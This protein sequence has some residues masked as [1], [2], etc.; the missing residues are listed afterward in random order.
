MHQS[1]MNYISLLFCSFRENRPSLR[2]VLCSLLAVFFCIFLGYAAFFGVGALP[3][4]LLQKNIVKAHDSGFFEENYPQVTVIAKPHRVDMY[5]ECFGVG[6]A[7]QPFSN[8]RDI[9]FTSSYGHCADLSRASAAQFVSVEPVAYYRYTHGYSIFVRL[10]YTYFDVQTVRTLVTAISCILLLTLTLCLKLRVSTGHALLVLGSFFLLN[11]PSMYVL[12]THAAQFWLVLIACIIVTLL[13]NPRY[14]F[15]IMA[16]VGALDG[17]V[18]F[19]SMGSL[20]LSMPL[21]CFMLTAVARIDSNDSAQADS[22]QKQMFNILAQGF[23]ACCAWSVGFLLP[24]FFKWGAL[25]FIYDISW[26]D[27]FGATV[28]SYAAS[29]IGMIA[30]AIFKNALATH[31]GVWVLLFALLFW[32][33]YKEGRRM[34]QTLWITAFPALMPLIWCVLLPGQSGVKHSSFV[35]LILWPVFCFVSFYLFTPEKNARFKDLLPLNLRKL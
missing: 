31:V 6:T 11:S 10:F 18:T 12:V 33:R 19:L 23:Y 35:N 4:D 2:K 3:L 13:S 17:F 29:G 21:L 34:A 32:I 24:W 30:L 5:T 9:L 7:L 8:V 20:S 15:P 28:Q 16:V 25:H 26:Q 22:V 27:I 1:F 14:F